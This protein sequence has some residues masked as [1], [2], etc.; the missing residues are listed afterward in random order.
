LDTCLLCGKSFK[1]ITNSHIKK[2]H[3]TTLKFYIEQFLYTII[4]WNKGVK[5]GPQSIDHI[6]RRSRKEYHHSIE[7]KE[8]IRNSNIGKLKGVKRSPRTESHKQNLSNSLKGRSL[9][10]THIQNLIKSHTKE[11]REKSR[12]TQKNNF[13]NEE[14]IKKFVHG[15]KVTPNKTEKILINIISDLKLKYKFTGDYK[16]WIG[17]KN[18]DFIDE[19]NNKIIEFFGWRHTEEATGISNELHEK[20]RIN[21]FSKHGYN[22]LVLWESDIKDIEKLK[23][24]ILSF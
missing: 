23:G 15:S 22:C 5:T 10:L 18:P 9:S 1:Q 2:F 21:H 12:I 3:N 14:F 24:K 13:K 8:K 19:E 4:P 11:R 7:T 20:E 17:G 16:I 6:K